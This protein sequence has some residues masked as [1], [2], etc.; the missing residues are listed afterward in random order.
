MVGKYFN[1]VLEAVVDMEDYFIKPPT[2]EMPTYISENR[3][4]MPYFK[5]MYLNI[6]LIT[7]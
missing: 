3:R 1:K 6:K 2:L 7:N 4:F 5:V